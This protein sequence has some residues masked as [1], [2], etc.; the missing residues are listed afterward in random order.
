MTMKI[1]RAFIIVG[2]GLLLV[3]ASHAD[4]KVVQAMTVDNPQI[5]AAMQNMSPDQRAM[6][7]KAGMGGAV[8]LTVYV[9]GKKSRIDFGA[10]TSAIVNEGAGRVT[11]LN[12]TARTFSTQSLK[13]AARKSADRGN[14]S[15]EATGKSKTIL[16]HLCREYRVS[17]GASAGPGSAMSG[18]MWVAGD[19]P[20][21]SILAMPAG[22]AATLESQWNKVRGMPLQMTFTITG[23][24]IGKTVVHSTAK[25]ISKT[26]I[27]ASTFAIPA[28]YKAGPAYFS[29]MMGGG[30]VGR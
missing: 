21:P 14:A 30:G 18:E 15:I 19:L 12:R 25:S 27:P 3:G 1:F 28:G 26:P 10:F 29:P 20:R 11:V 6:M 23:A 7:A 4:V 17:S 9:S 24:Q 22:E 8:A 5:K 16:G 13:S 2:A